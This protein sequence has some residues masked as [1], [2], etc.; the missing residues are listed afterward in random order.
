MG[1][2]FVMNVRIILHLLYCNKNINRTIVSLS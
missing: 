2:Q 1:Y